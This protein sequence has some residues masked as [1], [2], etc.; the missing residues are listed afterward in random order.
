MHYFVT[1]KNVKWCHLI[2]PT[3][4]ITQLDYAKHLK[5]SNIIIKVHVD[6]LVTPYLTGDPSP[7]VHNILCL[8]A[9]DSVKRSEH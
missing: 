3:L 7:L 2:W 1:S 9:S 5:C 8:Q 4:Y 6:T